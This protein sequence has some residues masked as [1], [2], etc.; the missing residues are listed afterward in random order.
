MK[1]TLKSLFIA[2]ALFIPALN[3][4][5]AASHKIERFMQLDSQLYR[6]AQPQTYDDFMALKKMGIKTIINMRASADWIVWEDQ[7]AE[8][9][10]MK[11]YSFPLTILGPLADD[12][13]DEILDIVFDKSYGPIFLHCRHGKDRTGMISAIYRVKKQGW[14]RTR[15][16]QEMIDMGFDARLVHLAYTYWK[17]VY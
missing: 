10:G 5:Y 2:V 16:W 6:G 17:N 8:K 1:K 4:A 3:S 11:F 15:A 7:I 9:L 12:T 14:S 13:I